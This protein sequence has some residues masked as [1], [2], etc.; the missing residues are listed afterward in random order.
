MTP[1]IPSQPDRVAKGIAYVLSAP[2]GTGKT[3]VLNRLRENVPELELSVSHTTRAPR[4]GEK[5]GIDYHFVSGETFQVMIQKGEFLEWAEIC[6]NHYGTALQSINNRL[7]SGKDLV[8]ELDVQ[9]A[10][11]LRGLK[12]EGV[13][14]FVLPPS[15][16][17][18]EARLR[19]RGT[20]S[21]QSIRQRLDLGK[22]EIKHYS[23]YD[24]VV[25]NRDVDATV[26][27]PACH[28]EGGTLPGR[29]IFC[30]VGRH[31]DTA[32]PE[33]ERLMS[34]V[35]LMELVRGKVKAL[36]PY[37]VETSR[38]EVKLHANENPFGPPRELLE[39]FR[40]SLDGFEF[41]RY[42]DP[43]S[44]LLK[45]AIGKRIGVPVENLIIGNGSDELLQLILQVFCDAGEPFA[46]SDPTFAMYSII[47]TGMGLHPMVVDLDDAWNLSAADFLNTTN[48]V[49]PRVI[50]VSYPNNPT[51]N[52][53]SEKEIRILIDTFQ[54]I[55]V[56][57]EAY[58]D[59]SGKTF[60][61]DIEK[62][63]N[64]I[65]LRSLSKIG[66]AALRVGY[67]VANPV[68]I[69]QMNKVRLP[70]NSNTLSQTFAAWMLENFDAVQ[71]QIET[72]L[73][74]RD[75]LASEL[76]GIPRL[77]VYP[78]DANFILF[79]VPESGEDLFRKLMRQSILV[80]NL[81]AHP[82]LKNCMRV[83]VGTREENDRFLEQIKTLLN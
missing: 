15:L 64:L 35:D 7:E 40:K 48:A 63:N 17:E 76:S 11:S 41:N 51:G 19:N 56:L 44:L 57:D 80:R 60:I 71:L 70:Y 33:G 73:T 25:V 54:G 39:R 79:R 22:E 46:F 21:E 74:E 59:F 52:C 61:Q 30:S 1:K 47:G 62:H 83:T 20:D 68:V 45:R 8:L 23:L 31:P 27:G 3:T 14:V 28:P 2:S 67:G 24:Y 65:V 53:Y 81:N 37:H 38:C 77:T 12:F 26:Q 36:N 49:H 6:G 32:P 43:D 78:S 50:F 9:G 66:L 13:F 4:A 55:V 69:E 10:E 82:R 72:I 18:L 58:F 75:R 29:E 42:P 5:D 34:N 16:K